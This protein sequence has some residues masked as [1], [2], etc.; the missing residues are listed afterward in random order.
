RHRTNEPSQSSTKL[1]A[2]PKSAG[3]WPPNGWIVAIFSP[4]KRCARFGSNSQKSAV[5]DHKSA[6]P[7]K[8]IEIDVA[9]GENNADAFS[10][11]VDLL[12]QAIVRRRLV[13]RD[14]GER[15]R[16][17]RLDDDL[18]RLPNCAHRRDDRFFTDGH[19]AI[20]VALND[21]KSI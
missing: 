1:S 13:F 19:N 12:C 4:P 17:R 5:R 20:D 7:G 8:R 21:L 2:Q 15:N 6:D 11:E 3:I 10:G 9:A 16:G 14:R 18:H